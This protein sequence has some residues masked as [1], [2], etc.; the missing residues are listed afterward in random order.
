M[1]QLPVRR[2]IVYFVIRAP[3]NVMYGRSLGM[4]PDYFRQFR[5]ES[6]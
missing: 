1:N 3:T 6:Q 5:Y 2:G 4:V